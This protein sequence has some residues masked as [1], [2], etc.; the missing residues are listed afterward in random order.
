MNRVAVLLTAALAL[1][2]TASAAPRTLDQIRAS[3]TLKLGTEG[4]FPPFNFYQG[5]NLI[6]FEVDLG[7]ALAREMG[8]KPQWVV[9]PFDSLLIALNQGRFDAVLASHAIT[10]E[11]QKAVT[12]L[13]PH[14]CSTVNIVAQKG[15]PLT[16]AALAGKTVGT[17]IGT[18]QIPIL[19]A[20]PGIKDVRTFPND[21]TI[22]TALQAGRVDA[23]SSNGPV[24]AY[25]LKQTGQQGKIVIGEAISQEHNAGAVAKGNTALH[26]ALNGAL[27]TLMKDGT[28]A[29]LSQK[30]FGQDIRC[31]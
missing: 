3:G 8:L 12:F 5:K 14:Y 21:Q 20:I 27:A 10:P 11:R 23:W 7:N 1:S 16:R 31:K 6:G 18:A 29:K 19:Q 17:Q 26:D 9:Q 24:V 4:A 13:N 15:G 25:M 22:L 30:W 28:Y 2:V